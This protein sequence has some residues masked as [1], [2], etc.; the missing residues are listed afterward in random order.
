MSDTESPE[1]NS[2]V[3]ELS[4][5]ALTSQ[6]EFKE[7][8]QTARQEIQTKFIEFT[9]Q[10]KQEETRLLEKLNEIDNDILKKFS[11]SSKTLLEISQARKQILATLK[12]N[13]TNTLLKKNLEMYDKEI[14]SI[15]KKSKID[16]STIQLKWNAIQFEK[17]CELKL[18][19]EKVVPENFPFTPK[20]LELITPIPTEPVLEYST[21]VPTPLYTELLPQPEIQSGGYH[22]VIAPYTTILPASSREHIS[23]NITQSPGKI[24]KYE[25]DSR[26]QCPYC[27]NF[28]LMKYAFCENCFKSMEQTDSSPIVAPQK[29]FVDS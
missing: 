21:Q 26:W 19:T 17:I 29:G 2:P 20:L 27:F 14:E 23:P 24:R 11:I 13:T 18:H 10:L 9:D 4:D 22:S 15:K 1:S 5:E 12:S 6:T 28:N 25:C 3:V 16:T 8:I 7:R